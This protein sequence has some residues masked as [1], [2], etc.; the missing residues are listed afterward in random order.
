MQRVIQGSE[1]I[2]TGIF[3]CTTGTYRHSVKRAEVMHFLAGRGR[4]TPVRKRPLAIH[5]CNSLLQFTSAIHFCNSLLQFTS[6]IHFSYVHCDFYR[7]VPFAKYFNTPD[8]PR[9]VSPLA[10]HPRSTQV[11][12]CHENCCKRH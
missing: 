9:R 3:E 4:V 2:D 1:A 7:R 6:A 12:G 5:F 11:F 10:I 8:T